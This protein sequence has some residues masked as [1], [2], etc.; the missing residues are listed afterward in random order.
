MGITIALLS[1]LGV[2]DEKFSGPQKGEKTPG[3]KVF[4]VGTR[5]ETD[6]VAEAR[7]APL[8]LVFIHELSRPGAQLMRAL[9]DTGQ[10]KQA[11]GLRTF[12]ISLTE[13]RDGAERHLPQVVKSIQ[14][15]CPIGI[16]LDG[17]EGP[18]AYGLNR[19]VMITV[20]VARGDRVSANFAILSPN[21]TDAPKIRAAVDEALKGAVEAPNG[22]PE[23]L[24]AE[25]VRLR[26]QVLALQEEL[27]ALK[28]RQSATTVGPARRP[29]AMPE[30]EKP[31]EDP[32]LVNHCRRLIQ[33][34]A[35]QADLDAAVKD[36]E[37]MIA[38]KDDL[39][40]QYAGILKRVL[41]LKYGNELGQAVMRAQLEKHG[42]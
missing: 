26:E 19:E 2:Q 12:F 41:D 34:A 39:R 37:T 21:E 20:V 25:I 24:K 14:L 11:R 4:D 7:G 16:S 38:G 35:T 31:V 15:K 6:Y 28:L 30:M 32:N 5:K 18:G 3:F 27:A 17:R 8:L 40:K 29:G 36:I 33:R 42:K 22:T 23:E 1:L 10:I 13:D 9:D